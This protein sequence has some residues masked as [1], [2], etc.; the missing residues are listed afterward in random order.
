MKKRALLSITIASLLWLTACGGGNGDGNDTADDTTN[1]GTQTETG[2]Y[3]VIAANDLGMH[4]IDREFSVFSILPPFNVV[5]A[6]VVGHESDGRPVLVDDAAVEV[7]Y[8]ATTDA[9]GSINSYSS[10]KTDFWDYAGTLFSTSLA[11]GEGLTGRYMPQDAPAPGAQLFDFNVTYDW[12]TADGIPIT[13]LDDDDATNPYPLM[14]I[15]AVD[16]ATGDTLGYTDIV[17]PVASETDCRSCH[18]TGKIGTSR[19]GITWSSDSDLEVQSKKNILRLHNALVGT[20]FA[21]NTP[22]LCAGCHYSRALDLEEAG[23]TV[24]QKGK[25]TFSSAMHNYHGKLTDLGG[26]ILPDTLSSCYSCHPGNITRCLRGAMGSAG[27]DCIDCH[28]GMLAVGAEY[29]LAAGGSMDGSNDGAPR[30]PWLDLP[31]C[32]SCHTGDAVDHLTGPGLTVYD[33]VF[34]FRLSQAYLTGDD[35][36]SPLLAAN[37]RFAENDD[38]LFRFSKGHGGLLCEGC[39][40]ST[41]A[42]WPN[43]TADANDN[44]AA[45]QLQGYAGKIIECSTCHLQ[46]SLSLTTNGPHGLHN[47]NDSRWVDENHGNYFEGSSTTCRRCHGADLLGTPLSRAAADRSFNVEEANNLTKGEMVRCNR[48]HGMPGD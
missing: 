45:S 19:D 31:R 4:C 17:V 46:G 29:D 9:S 10:G 24:D 26:K 23:P 12:F 44:V 37:K 2:D 42:E 16:P 3:V 39:H 38:T 40:G 13:P 20:A 48:C 25:P 35:A 21:N 8:D 11:D 22:V 47:V 1:D 30:R 7:T 36:A 18:A 32:Q 27:M 14:R 34:P 33:S 43:E 15:S 28:G 5:N 6:Q 41:H